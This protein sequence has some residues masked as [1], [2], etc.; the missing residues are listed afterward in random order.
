[1]SY[2]DYLDTHY[3][4]C[5]MEDHAADLSHQII[6]EEYYDIGLRLFKLGEFHESEVYYGRALKFG[7]LLGW[8]EKEL[9][10]YDSIIK[11]EN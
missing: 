4:S 7:L 6:C 1:M 10:T 2:S 9:P 3:S 8:D 5:G 11:K